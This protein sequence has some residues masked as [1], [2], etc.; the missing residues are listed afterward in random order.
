MVALD[1]IPY[2][3]LLVQFRARCAIII[4]R[5]HPLDPFSFVVHFEVVEAI[6]QM[7]VG[8]KLQEEIVELECH[9]KLMQQLV[10]C[11]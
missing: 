5:A 3:M 7:V 9:W 1:I 2:G 11:I 4:Y 8:E 6:R 10:D